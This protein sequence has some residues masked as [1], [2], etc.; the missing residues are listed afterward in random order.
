MTAAIRSTPVRDFA[1]IEALAPKL[2]ALADAAG[3]YT[4]SHPSFFL[5]W[6]RAAVA[7]GQVPECLA[8]WRKR[9]LVGFVPLFARRDKKALM[10][11]RLM[12]PRVGTS[13]PFALLAAPGEDIGAIVDIAQR[14]LTASDW[15][16]MTFAGEPRD[17]I[18]ATLWADRY[19]EAGYRVERP[20]LPPSYVLRDCP[21]R[22]AFLAGMKG[23]RRKVMRRLERKFLERGST[24]CDNGAEG[25]EAIKSALRA[26]IGASW[27]NAGAMQAGGL[28]LLEALID[29]LAAVGRLAF[30]S[31]DQDG[32]P[33]GI[34]M[35]IVD[36]D[37]T[38][39]AYFN[40]HDRRPEAKNTGSVLLYRAVM[41][42]L[43]RGLGDCH[44]WGSRDYLRHYAND[45]RQVTDLT[46]TNR[47]ARAGLARAA[48]E[49]VSGIR[50]GAAR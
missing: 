11:R 43:D 49:L 16:D 5:P 18:F 1:G 44:F 42:G 48:T 7:E 17:T 28:D 41:E 47:G 20:E 36:P 30:W 46:I 35:E 27:K 38:R 29:S 4:Y 40:A 10:A 6:A 24:R 33:V 2:A 31:A 15:A 26:V 21:D 39:H 3:A 8:L 13:P 50:R 14:E 23:A 19:A 37:G 32:R 9:T 45:S 12:P 25:T 34:Y 22:D